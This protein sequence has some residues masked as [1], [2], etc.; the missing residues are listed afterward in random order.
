MDQRTQFIAE[1]LRGGR[2]ITELCGHPGKPTTQILA[3]NDVWGPTT[4]GSSGPAT[5]AT[6]IR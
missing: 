1:H 2:T 4:K 3:P 6:A 5:A